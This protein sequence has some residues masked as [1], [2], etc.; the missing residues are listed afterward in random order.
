MSWKLLT[1]V[2][3]LALLI[4]VSFACTPDEPTPAPAVTQ[5]PRA[6]RTIMP[7]DAG[8]TYPI[9]VN[10]RPNPPVGVSVLREVR[11][12]A[13]PEGGGWDRIVFE[14][15]DSLPGAVVEY[16]PNVVGCGSGLPLRLQG[17]AYLLVRFYP[18]QAHNDAGQP[19]IRS[20]QV[21]GPGNS[22][23]EA[24]SNCDYE[25]E[26]AWAVGLSQVTNFKVTTLTNPMRLVIDVSW[27]R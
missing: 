17:R 15:K 23:L 25:A 3:I 6:D 7:G 18:A 8:S 21:A 12:G 20:L 2:F 26:V 13:H 9:S 4:A 10:P 5:L 14:F 16:V 24:K 19:T 27:N 22:I 11:V 1:F